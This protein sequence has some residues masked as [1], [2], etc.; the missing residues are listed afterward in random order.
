MSGK[1][2][3]IEATC[4]CGAVRYEVHGPLSAMVHCHCSMC[5]KHHGGSFATFAAAP[6][7]GFRWIAGEDTVVTHASSEKGQR[8]FCMNC[9]SVAPSVHKEMDMVICPAGNL[10][11]DLDLKPQ[12]HW[13]V[14]SRAPWTQIT[15][16]LPQHEEYPED[17]GT[18]GVTRMAAEKREGIVA[19]SCLC[20]SVAFEI[21]GAPLR[22]M[23][24]HCTRCRR[25]R[26]SAHATNLFYRL[27]DFRFVRGETHV[28]VYR[29]PE[30]RFFAVA[31]CR[32]CGGAAPRVSTER[33]AVIVPAGTL[34]NDPGTRPEAHIFVSYKAN[35]FDI[36]DSLPQFPEGA[37]P[38]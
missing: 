7:M 14:G 20:G 9:G 11:G 38:P 25:G 33:G 29:V 23:N 37:P 17:F 26:S 15:D 31:F 28:R 32:S 1:H 10:L 19:G 8:S 27:D 13:F 35:W 4:L 2:P 34:D 22:M 5:R 16:D 30:A 24:C 36:V 12:A 21:T 3:P 6:L 18:T